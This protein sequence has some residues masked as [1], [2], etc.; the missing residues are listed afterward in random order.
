[1]IE[2]PEEPFTRDKPKRPLIVVLATLLGGMLGVAIVLVR[3]VF[4]RPDEA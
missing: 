3:H 1:M 2:S 4:R